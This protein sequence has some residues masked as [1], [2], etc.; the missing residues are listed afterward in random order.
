MIAVYGKIADLVRKVYPSSVE[1]KGSKDLKEQL[2]L[3]PKL[4]SIDTLII[5]DTSLMGISP[6]VRDIKSA[7]LDRNER[8]RVIIHTKNEK[9]KSKM[10]VGNNIFTFTSNKLTEAVL[11]EEVESI[12][13]KTVETSDIVSENEILRTDMVSTADIKSDT[14]DEVK[15]DNVSTESDDFLLDKPYPVP[16]ALLKKSLQNVEVEDVNESP[17]N[18]DKEEVINTST[19]IPVEI[20][21]STEIET[22][23]PDYVDDYLTLEEIQNKLEKNK[24]IKNL[25][26]TNSEYSTLTEKFRIL[27]R[28]LS[29]VLKSNDLTSEQKLNQMYDI[30]QEKSGIKSQTNDILANNVVSILDTVFSTAVIKLSDG[31]EQCRKRIASISEK[32]LYE[33]NTVK[34]NSLMDMRFKLQ[35]ELTNK[36]LVIS[37]LFQQVSNIVSDTSEE[38][39]NGIPSENPYIA[40]YLKPMVGLAPKDL[41]RH[42]RELFKGLEDGRL[43]LSVVENEIRSLLD[44]TSKLCDVSDNV[45]ATQQELIDTMKVN[46]VEQVVIIDNLLKNDLRLYIGGENSGKTATIVILNEARKRKGNSLLIDL[47]GKNK[48]KT[49]LSDIHKLEDI[50][51]Q[52]N[53]GEYE[54]IYCQSPEKLDKELLIKYLE[55]CIQHY[56][57]INILLDA[58]TNTDLITYLHNYALS[59][60]IVAQSNIPSINTAKRAINLLT[61]KNIARYLCITNPAV[62]PTEIFSIFDIAPTDYKYVPIPNMPEIARCS[63]RNTNP[64]FIKEIRTVFEEGF[65]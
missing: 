14:T 21:P 63:I 20:S 54:N 17:A 51:E 22:P 46:K 35:T 38:F 42:V 48:I 64:G 49:Y 45:I 36:L 10:P 55:D 8:I 25:L 5:Q 40:S 58:D 12:I 62:A 30:V 18:T 47:T 39:A 59:V 37:K 60:T 41:S 57:Y 23:K 44:T 16:K 6:S 24:I 26:V 1:I 33:G 52:C 56:R 50:I 31:I 11:K 65:E 7:L 61:S 53:R 4:S 19:E 34:I 29:E 28:R 2:I 9:N 32:E 3:D 27:D 43:K 13:A 15:S